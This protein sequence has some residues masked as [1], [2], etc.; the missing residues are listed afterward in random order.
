MRISTSNVF[1]GPTRQMAL[2]ASQADKLQTQIS[3]GLRF[4]NASEDATGFRRVTALKRDA[5][6]DTAWASNIKLAQGLLAQGDT[7]LQSVETQLQRAQELAM[8]AG[9]SAMTDSDKA[10]IA[11]SIEVMIE[12]LLALANSKDLRG[13]P[14]FGGAA[15]D[16]AFARNADGSIG[17]TGTGDP[18][19]IPIGE[20]SSIHPTVSG[21]AA[22]AAGD[23][24]M[25]AVLQALSAALKT[26]GDVTEA[27]GDALD[28]IGFALEQVAGARSSIGARAYRLDL[29]MERIDAAEITREEA[30]S[31]IEGVDMSTAIG[32]LQKTLTILQATQ[33]SFTKLTSLSLFDYIR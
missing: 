21:E 14:L 18:A 30:R 9:N 15:G 3:T 4:T 16:S 11:R 29:E 23:S 17:Y 22:F 12:D 19:S 27:V 25:F 20:D 32:E 33:A 6:S 7:A 8:Q 13:Q 1:S 2:L 5:A 31:G 10:Q 26:G 28:G 24:D